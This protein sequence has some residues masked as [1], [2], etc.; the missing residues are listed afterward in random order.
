MKVSINWLRDYVDVDLSP[1]EL[2]EKLTMI[3]LEVKT[4]SETKDK[5]DVILDIEITPNRPDCLSVLGIAREIGT[6]TKGKLKRKR[7]K[8]KNK[9][10]KSKTEIKIEIQD[11]K[12]CLRYTGKLIEN[13]KIKPSPEWMQERLFNLGLRP[14]NNVVDI[15]NYIMLEYGQP[16]DHYP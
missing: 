4:I 10:L 6:I 7:K 5:K 2:A 11:K 12:G 16:K 3:G 15:T 9:K 13:I 8:I 14:I 1:Q